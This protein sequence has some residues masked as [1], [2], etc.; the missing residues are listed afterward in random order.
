MPVSYY[1]GVENNTHPTWWKDPA[2]RRNALWVSLSALMYG[3]KGY[4]S[5]MLNSAQAVPQFYL[6]FPSLKNNSTL[7][8]LTTAVMYLPGL[9][10]PFLG[11]WLA[12]KV[13]RKI[14]LIIAILGAMLTPIIQAT[15]KNLGQ[16]IAGRFLMGCFSSVGAVSGLAMCAELSHPRFRA[17]AMSLQLS[18]YYIGN[19]LC[20][21]VAYACITHIGN[22]EWSWRIPFLTQSVLPIL[23]LPLAIWIP[24]SPRWLVAQGREDEARKILANLHANGK[25]DDPL[26]TMEMDEVANAIELERSNTEGWS[27]LWR[28]KANRWRTWIVVHSAAGAQLNGIGIIAYYL[29]PMLKVVGITDSRQQSVLIIGMGVMNLGMNTAATYVVDR[30]GRRP[31]WISSTLT[32]LVCLSAITGLSASFQ[33]SPNPA[34]GSATVAFIFLFY[35]GFDIG[36]MPLGTPYTT[37]ILP[38]GI[39]AKGIG[40]STVSTY[41]ALC[42]NTFVNPIAMS[43]ISWKYYFVYIFMCCYLLVVA[44]FTFPETKGRTLEQIGVVFGDLDE[45]ALHVHRGNVDLEKAPA[46]LQIENKPDNTVVTLA[47]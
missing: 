10:L 18:M 45:D 15:S 47:K 11:A 30:A 19:I 20:S 23:C 46:D 3:V 5:G 39:R 21:S 9:F 16:L 25:M 14:P 26:V 34:I 1:N 35:C 36:W 27:A 12:D 37:E 28:T 40:L 44:Y 29:V 24:Q 17:Q 43:K 8:G 31:M 22:S 38:F 4:D 33:K 2:L 32:M 42:I 6:Q 7:L 41:G 13:G